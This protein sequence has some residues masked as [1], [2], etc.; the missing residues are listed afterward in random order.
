MKFVFGFYLSSWRH[1]NNI[2]S[3][4]E[5]RLDDSFKFYPD[6]NENIRI[7]VY[8]L[9]DVPKFQG[10]NLFCKYG[11]KVKYDFEMVEI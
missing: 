2:Y 10:W 8:D 11:Y 6:C 4:G 5:H 1:L 9:K 7:V 3:K